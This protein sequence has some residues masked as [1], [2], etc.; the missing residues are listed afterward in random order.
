[1]DIQYLK[2]HII[3]NNLISTILE[4][5][6]C[7]HIS[8]KTGYF[9]CG[10][11]DGDN[12]TAISVYENECLTTIDYTRNLSD[13]NNTDIF[14][15]IK[16]FLKCNFFEAI[17][18][19]CDW[20]DLDYYKDPYEDL[21][22]SLKIT[23]L[24]MEMTQDNEND[25]D[26]D[27]KPL[28]PISEKI[29]TYYLPWQNDLF[30]KDNIDYQTQ[31]EFEIGYDDNTNRITIPIRDELNTLVGVKGRLFIPK[32][33]ITEDEQKYKYLYIEPCNKSKI[34]FG[35]YKTLPYISK[36]SEVY[37]TES[38]KGVMQLWSMGVF[39]ATATCG[40]KVSNTQIEKLTRLC[41][42]IIF[43]FDKDVQRE[44]IQELSEKFID[45]VEIFAV[46][47]TNGILD[48]KES[49]TDNPNKFK[50]LIQDCCERI[51]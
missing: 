25:N 5:L 11:P 31:Q 49:P 1:M 29:L 41:A 10:N 2:N 28:K 16:F 34:L 21:P 22:E 30:L 50:K 24:L 32:E 6:G 7:H 19:V 45:S 18:Q 17:K 47:D 12:P 43:L 44:E 36:K 46:I 38:E 48:E 33:Q 26:S 13:K 39:N 14:D 40:K 15:L 51:R 35:L 20:V 9:T 37:V 23:K 27:D 3:E 4:Q 42:K 8:H